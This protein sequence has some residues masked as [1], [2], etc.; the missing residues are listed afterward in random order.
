MFCNFTDVKKKNDINVSPLS[1]KIT[2]PLVEEKQITIEGMSL[3][4]KC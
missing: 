1:L 4:V 2:S 3:L